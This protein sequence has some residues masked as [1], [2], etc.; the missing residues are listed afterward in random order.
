MGQVSRALVAVV[1]E[2]CL[3][4]E[5]AL[6]PGCGSGFDVL[7][8]ASKLPGTAGTATGLDLSEMAVASATAKAQSLGLEGRARFRTADFFTLDDPDGTYDLVYD[9]T[10]LC[11]IEPT[12]R[13]A[14]AAQ[15]ARLTRAGGHFITYMYPIGDHITG[16][17][18]AVHP[19]HYDALLGAHFERLLLRDILPGE[20]FP[21]RV[22]GP[23]GEMIALWR[24]R[25]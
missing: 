24:R 9:H 18:Y 16:P 6:V 17:P 12:L 25:G 19:E 7:Y 14:W 13:P 4:F 22:D 8:F 11:A 2:Q 15:I 23:H 1:E 3:V 10:F 5:R 21:S 20:K